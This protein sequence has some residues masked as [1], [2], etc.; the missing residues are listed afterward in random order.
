MERDGLT[1]GSLA[2]S[3]TMAHKRN[4]VGIVELQSLRPLF[5]WLAFP[6]SLRDGVSYGSITGDVVPG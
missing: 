3:A 5:V 2:D 1:Q 6:P 4:S